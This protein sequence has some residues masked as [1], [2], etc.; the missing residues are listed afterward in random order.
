MLPHVSAHVFNW[1]NDGRYLIVGTQNTAAHRHTI[2]V[3]ELGLDVDATSLNVIYRANYPHKVISKIST[4]KQGLRFASTHLAEC[5]IWDPSRSLYSFGNSQSSSQHLSPL[6]EPRGE[7]SAMVLSED[8]TVV[9]CGNEHGEIWAYSTLDGSEIGALHRDHVSRMASRLA[10]AE[11]ENQD[12]II[13]CDWQGLVTILES[14]HSPKR[15]TKAVVIA[16]YD[17][18][19]YMIEQLLVSPTK[20]RLLIMTTMNSAVLELPSGKLAK[21][22]DVPKYKTQKSTAQNCPSD[23]S[24]FIIFEDDFVHIFD[25]N[26]DESDAGHKLEILR[27]GVPPQPPS[28]PSDTLHFMGNGLYVESLVYPLE[29]TMIS[30]WDSAQF[31]ISGDAT[32]ITPYSGFQ[33][34]NDVLKDVLLV[35]DTTLIFVD[36]NSWVCTLDLKTFASTCIVKRHFF[37]LP[38]WT[39]TFGRVMA[40][41]APNHDLIFVNLHRIVVVKDWVTSV[42]TLVLEPDDGDWR[43]ISRRIKDESAVLGKL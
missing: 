40:A 20:D 18:D 29:G 14:S 23:A 9:I 36:Y 34:L 25:W 28:R 26:D 27:E 30:C 7:I 42:Q 6:P 3:Y 35:F 2:E 22:R 12:L 38:E 1:S 15:W 10:L 16:D 21:Y 43:V 24:Q 31:T 32:S 37:L 5:C 41:M 19:G 4:A 17:L 11:R 39:E 8:G 13:K 33:H